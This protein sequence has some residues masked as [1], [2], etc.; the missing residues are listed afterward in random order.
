MKNGT[1]TRN[2]NMFCL[3]H[4]DHDYKVEE[5]HALETKIE[6]FI[7]KGYLHHLVKKKRKDEHRRKEVY[8]LDDLPNI[9]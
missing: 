1:N 2:P 9:K 3:F 6:I 7:T 4:L 8:I 5:C